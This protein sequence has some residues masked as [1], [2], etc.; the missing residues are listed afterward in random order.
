MRNDSRKKLLI[1]GTENQKTAGTEK[2]TRFAIACLCISLTSLGFTSALISDF[3]PLRLYSVLAFIFVLLSTLGLVVFSNMQRERKEQ[4]FRHRMIRKDLKSKSKRSRI[5]IVK[6]DL[7]HQEP[8]EETHA[9]INIGMNTDQSRLENHVFNTPKSN[10]KRFMKDRKE[11]FA[12]ED[13]MEPLY[14]IS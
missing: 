7:Q 13:R 5:R 14:T 1:L 10:S 6:E 9:S 2:T 3:S 4:E 8:D 11:W 12:D